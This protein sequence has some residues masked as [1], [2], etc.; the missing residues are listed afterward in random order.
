VAFLSASLKSL[1]KELGIPILC[2]SQLSRAPETRGGD[3]RPM[4]SDLRDSGAIEQDADIV[5]FVYR[6]EIYKDFIKSKQ[7]EIAGRKY[8]VEGIAEVIVAKNRNGPVGSVAL[9]FVRE[10]TMFSAVTTE[11][12]LVATEEE[13][14]EIEDEEPGAG[15]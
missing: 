6:P 11:A 8:D 1:A 15:F 14:I 7:Y 5:M 3:R 13:T 9:S 4:L 2:L 12:P 10:Y